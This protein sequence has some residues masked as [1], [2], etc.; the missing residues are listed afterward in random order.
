MAR[1]GKL[2]VGFNSNVSPYK[3]IKFYPRHAEHDALL[4]AEH[5]VTSGR[6]KNDKF[7]LIVIR[8]TKSGKLA[9]SAP[10]ENCTKLLSSSKYVK[11]TKIYFSD[12]N[13]KIQSYKFKDWLN[14]ENHHVSQ[15]W[16][17]HPNKMK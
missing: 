16:K 4:K 17:F 15:G 12:E 7:I 14:K 9:N 5:M 2:N 6:L 3:N 1:K 8:T 11:I 10:C 13:E